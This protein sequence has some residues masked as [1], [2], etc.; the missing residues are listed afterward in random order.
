MLTAVTLYVNSFLRTILGVQTYNAAENPMARDD[1]IAE[2]A[3]HERMAWQKATGDNQRSR[4]ETLM[5]VYIQ[6]TDLIKNPYS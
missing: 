1:H 3:N 4:G 5:Q 2:I 6:S